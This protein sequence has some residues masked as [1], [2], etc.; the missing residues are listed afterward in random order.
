MVLALL[1]GCSEPGLQAADA[2]DAVVSAN[3]TITEWPIKS[4]PAAVDFQ[5]PTDI[6]GTLTSAELR[7]EVVVLNTW[8]AGCAPCR[9]EAP[10]LQALS[11]QFRD[12]GVRFVGINTRDERASA[13]AFARQFGITYPSILDQENGSAVALALSTTIALRAVPTTLV[14]DR[15][16]RVA[17]RILGR[18]PSR[19]TLATL[20][21][22][23]LAE[24]R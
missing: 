1:S 19:N 9:A 20:I 2:E 13:Q 5:G 15:Q 6:G 10:D 17:A 24:P 18:I 7:S 12:D 11:E 16:G 23:T 3:G 4:R 21:R 8:Y 22:D 14:L